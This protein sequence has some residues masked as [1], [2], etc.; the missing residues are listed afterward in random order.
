MTNC[1]KP[2]PFTIG[3]PKCLQKYQIYKGKYCHD[4][5]L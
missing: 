2:R 1:F 3:I 5:L 4:E